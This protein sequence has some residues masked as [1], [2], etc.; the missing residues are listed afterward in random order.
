[1]LASTLLLLLATEV[2]AMSCAGEELRNDVTASV[3]LSL[4]DAFFS[5]AIT[6]HKTNCS[7]SFSSTTTSAQTE[8]VVCFKIQSLFYDFIFPIRNGLPT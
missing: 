8:E 6:T 5:K 7:E 1:M 4:E 2:S 3:V